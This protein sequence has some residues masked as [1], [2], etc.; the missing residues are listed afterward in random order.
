MAAEQGSQWTSYL[1]APLWAP[2]IT[3][4]A[5]PT[6]AAINEG[7]KPSSCMTNLVGNRK[8]D[9]GQQKTYKRSAI[10]FGEHEKADRHDEEKSDS[11]KIKYSR[12]VCLV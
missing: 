7:E 11:Q 6:P 1:E 10:P 8:G 5:L 2:L 12:H 3:S 9:P 4:T